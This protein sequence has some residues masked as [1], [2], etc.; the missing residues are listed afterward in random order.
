MTTLELQFDM[1]DAKDKRIRA[2]I[3]K[4]KSEAGN[5]FYCRWIVCKDKRILTPGSQEFLLDD[6]ARKIH[7]MLCC[8][9][10]LETNKQ[11]GIQ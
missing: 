1:L 4:A 2:G 3:A 7:L 10:E 5:C 9:P 6:A 11:Y 8:D